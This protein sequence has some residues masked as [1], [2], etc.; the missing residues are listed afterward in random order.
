M[1]VRS[2]VQAVLKPPF[3]RSIAFHVKQT[4]RFPPYP[5]C[6]ALSNSKYHKA[7]FSTTNQTLLNHQQHQKKLSTAPPP[8]PPPLAD[9]P[10]VSKVGLNVKKISPE[11][12]SDL[13]NKVEDDD[14]EAKARLG[15]IL[16]EG[17]ETLPK[18]PQ[19]GLKLLEE[20]AEEKQPFALRNLGELLLFGLEDLVEQNQVRA[21]ELFIAGATL[22]DPGCAGALGR[23][24][25]YGWGVQQNDEQAV[26]LLTY[27][28]TKGDDQGLECLAELHL[29]GRGVERDESAAF[30]LFKIAAEKG[31]PY[32]SIRYADC[33]IRG[34]GCEQDVEKAVELYEKLS[35]TNPDALN[36]LA[37]CHLSGF[38]V[39]KDLEKA[40][41]L[42]EL[43]AKKGS[44]GAQTNLANLLFS[45]EEGVEQ[46]VDR[47]VSLYFKAAE[48]YFA[49]AQLQ[50][51]ACHE[52]G[53]GVT[54]DKQKASDYYVLAGSQGNMTAIK[55]LIQAYFE[56]D[57]PIDEELARQ[58]IEK[59]VQ[60][61]DTGEGKG[62]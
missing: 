59:F 19:R 39:E 22:K 29:G 14:V 47:A 58:L 24:L 57:L 37:V 38:G 10:F 35:E 12:V 7:F 25:A 3:L 28:I 27:S 49:E 26:Q 36:N 11:Q 9:T 54:E 23:C 2:F 51:G 18:D 61:D 43:A 46:N 52:F 48:A 44:P 55:R 33:L 60:T 32:G 6:G 13:I 34:I 15:V 56:K 41:S 16:I 1:W 31:R 45:G 30:R 62:K 20:A 17:H 5:S 40:L 53:V 4:P 42:L 8:L 21:A 50:L